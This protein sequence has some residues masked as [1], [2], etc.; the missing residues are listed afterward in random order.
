[1]FQSR[2]NRSPQ[3]SML[4]RSERSSPFGFSDAACFFEGMFIFR[5]RFIK[6]EADEFGFVGVALQSS[7][8]SKRLVFLGTDVGSCQLGSGLSLV[9]HVGTGVCALAG[10]NIMIQH[11]HEAFELWLHISASASALPASILA[12]ILP[13]LKTFLQAWTAEG[14]EC[15]QR[16]L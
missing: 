12:P 4:I 9:R 7:N 5:N 6:Q 13:P 10:Q 8:L 15:R 2:L 16:K 1:M 3:V 11:H 14:H